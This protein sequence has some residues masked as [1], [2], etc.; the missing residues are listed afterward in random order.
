MINIRFSTV[1]MFDV[2]FGILTILSNCF[3]HNKTLRWYNVMF[4]LLALMYLNIQ[5][6]FPQFV[7][8]VHVYLSCHDQDLSG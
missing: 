7:V 4:F 5:T 6:M 2:H 3:K 1:L 8:S